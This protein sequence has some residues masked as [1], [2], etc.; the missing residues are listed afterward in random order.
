MYALR[1]VEVFVEI[2]T[3]KLV[4]VSKGFKEDLQFA[5]SG[6]SLF[7]WTEVTECKKVDLLYLNIFVKETHERK[8]RK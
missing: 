8:I 5:S 2:N 1:T 7:E 3:S 6:L 4:E